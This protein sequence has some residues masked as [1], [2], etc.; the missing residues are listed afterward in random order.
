MSGF[1][2]ATQAIDTEAELRALDDAAVGACVAFEGRVRNHNAG[3]AV[4]RLEYQAY[5]TL[6]LDV[7]N[8]ILAEALHRHAI[9]T[10]SC[11]HRVGLLEVGDLAVWVGVG[12]A[13]RDAAFAAC[14]FVID[15]IKARVPIWKNEHYADGESGWLHP[16]G[17]DPGADEKP[18][19]RRPR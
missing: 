13:H 15:A 12:A 1:R 2:L 17:T 9:A 6:A 7:G 11:V 5:A 8:S 4:V 10:V 19:G 3:R 14:R 16:G 18:P